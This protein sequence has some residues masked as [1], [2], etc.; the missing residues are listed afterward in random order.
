MRRQK[1]RTRRTGRLGAAVALAALALGAAPAAA[2][3]AVAILPGNVLIRFDTATPGTIASST[4][5]SGLAANQTIRGIDVRPATGKLYA[6]TVV[7]GSAANSVIQTYTID[8]ATGSA[9]F[10]GETAAALAGAADIP[11]GYDFNPALTA[12]GLGLVDRMRY[13]NSGVNDENARLNPDTGGLAGN[14]TDLTPAATTD[15]IAAAYDHNVSGTIGTTLFEIDRNTSTLSM[16]GGP[17]GAGS[18]NGGVVTDLGSLGVTL[19]AVSDAGFDISPT[20][21]AFAALTNNA[22]GV[23][24]LY[25]LNLQSST[26]AT[27]VGRLGSGVS[28]VLSLAILQPDTDG[29]DVRDAA[30]NCLAAANADQADLDGDGIGDACDPDQDGDGL[31][32]AVE[33]AI[34]SNPR[35]TN[36]DGD[37]V[38]D[39]SDACPALAGLAPSGCPDVSL[40]DTSIARGPARRTARRAATFAFTSTEAGSTFACRLDRQAFRPCRSPRTSGRLRLGAHAFEVRAIDAAGNLD[41][42]PASREWRVVASRRGRRAGRARRRRGAARIG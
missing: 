14:D 33:R 29:D 40:P 41:P 39:A 32:D 38:G 34:G 11:S 3:Q 10:V 22:D 35:S 12:N 16:Q 13:V 23:T 15:V 26:G 27:L 20:G 7:T 28:E 31:S 9:T 19:R 36:S 25:R 42:T 30:D 8:P 21:A 6:S 24:G 1:R 4:A 17:N 37:P 18:P 5:V 2:E